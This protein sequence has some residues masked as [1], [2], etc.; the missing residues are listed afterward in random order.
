MFI[1]VLREKEYFKATETDHSMLYSY[2]ENA[3]DAT[4][5][6]TEEK[7]ITALKISGFIAHGGIGIKEV[8]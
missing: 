7:L 4:K 3:E 1:A 2:S 6:D 8:D 5:F